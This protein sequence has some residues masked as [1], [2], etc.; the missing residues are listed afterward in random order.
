MWFKHE[1]GVWK[2]KSQPHT[3]NPSSN[4]DNMSY[5]KGRGAQINPHSRYEKYVYDEGTRHLLED[6]ATQIPTQYI[7]VFPKTIVNE[8]KSPDLPFDYSI[9][10]YQGCEHGCVY[11]YARNTHPYWGYSA[12]LDFEQKILYKKTAAQLLEKKLQSKRWKASP[13]MLSGNTDCY[14]PAEQKLEITRSL[15]KVFKKYR[16]PV[17]I[18]TKNSLILRDLD[19]LTELQKDSLVHVVITITSMD[20]A[21]RQLLEPRASSSSNRFKTVEALA[22]AGIPV[23]VMF[24]PIIPGLNEHEIFSI[25]QKS[26]E[27]GAQSMYYSIIRLNG[28]IALIF[29]DWLEKNYPNR[30]NKVL[31]KIKSFHGGNLGNSQFGK[32]MHGEGKVADIIRS[33]FELTQKKFFPDSK[34]H[35]FNLDLHQHY[36]SP[37]LKLFY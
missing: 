7:E 13:I 26:A 19:I 30:K 31:S 5:L 15:L 16:H 35:H 22:N 23:K 18:I 4:K 32:R 33:Q 25:A 1:L 20:D 28:D 9:N 21:L 29:E 8:V 2:A 17:S 27:A 6:G 14:Q 3:P 24:A 36:K 11:C 10:P 37:Q 12:G 34:K